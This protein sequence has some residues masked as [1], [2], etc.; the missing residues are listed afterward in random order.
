MGSNADIPAFRWVEKDTGRV[1]TCSA[2]ADCA[3]IEERHSSGRGLLAQG[4]ASRSKNLLSGDAA[5]VILTVSR[6]EAE[7]KAN[8]GYRAYLADGYNVTRTFNLFF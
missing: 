1:M 6:M 8:P 3:L 7:K 5:E 2:P 4:G